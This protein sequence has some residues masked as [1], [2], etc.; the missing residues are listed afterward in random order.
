MSKS[1]AKIIIYSILLIFYAFIV[2][3]VMVWT[4]SVNNIVLNN[5][6]NIVNIRQSLLAT[7]VGLFTILIMFISLKFLIPIID[8]IIEIFMD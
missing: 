4:N 7:A 5:I 6:L 3:S 8:G 1:G 2:N